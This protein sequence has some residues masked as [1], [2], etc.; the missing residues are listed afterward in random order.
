MLADEASDALMGSNPRL[1][2]TSLLVT[3]ALMPELLENRQSSGGGGGGGG[4]TATSPKSRAAK[5]MLGRLSLGGAKKSLAN[6]FAV[7]PSPPRSVIRRQSTGG[8]SPT[9]AA[10]MASASVRSGR[11]GNG[12]RGSAQAQH[13]REALFGERESGG[14][15]G[16]RSAEGGAMAAERGGGGGGLSG[17]HA[18]VS[19]ARDLA[20]QRGEKLENMVDK[21]RQLEDSA[22]A[23]GDMAKELRKQQEDQSCSIS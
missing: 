16:D 5:G 7:E 13:Q 23:F 2:K 22:M 12:R 20:I 18:A 4:E 8:N 9:T 6:V 10:S 19:E 21:S 1:I 17:T 3:P 15:G 11:G 14:G